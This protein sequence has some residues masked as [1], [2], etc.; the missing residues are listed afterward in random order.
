MQEENIREEVKFSQLIAITLIVDVE[1]DYNERLYR[2][3][4]S[5]IQ[6]L[7]LRKQS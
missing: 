5:L 6:E 2:P 4:I 7:D 3:T 1:D